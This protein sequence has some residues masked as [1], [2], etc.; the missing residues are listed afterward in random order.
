VQRKLGGGPAW[1]QQR[2]HGDSMLTHPSRS[3]GP[4]TPGAGKVVVDRRR[5]DPA[6]ARAVASASGAFQPRE[7]QFYP[8]ST[9]SPGPTGHGAPSANRTP[10]PA[11]RRLQPPPGRASRPHPRSR[12][13]TT[14]PPKPLYRDE[15]APPGST[16]GRGRSITPH[17]VR[18]WRT[19]RPGRSTLRPAGPRGSTT[20]PPPCCRG[21][22]PA[23]APEPAST[24]S[25]RST[26]SSPKGAGGS[27]SGPRLGLLIGA[28]A[29]VVVI[30]LGDRVR[31][32]RHRRPAGTV[33]STSVVGRPQQ[34]PADR[35][36][37]SSQ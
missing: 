1:R 2:G 32:S 19:R 23:D 28:V 37:P 24:T 20:R 27:A 25:T 8:W 4:D 10:I 29:A 22:G 30:G 26:T 36:Q 13:W 17:R 31:R 33:P 14:K 21:P 9:R 3:F 34:P 15:V 16:R 7:E 5:R 6:E 18:T 35:H 11:K 12:S